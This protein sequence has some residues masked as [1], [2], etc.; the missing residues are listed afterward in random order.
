MPC[1]VWTPISSALKDERG[2]N[3]RGRVCIDT[4]TCRSNAFRAVDWPVDGR[5]AGSSRFR[6]QAT[7]VS[8]R[9]AAGFV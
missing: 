1:V 8:D 6:R 4:A 2:I 3:V 5:I 7:Y 9:C